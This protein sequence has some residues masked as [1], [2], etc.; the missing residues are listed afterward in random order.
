MSITEIAGYRV[1]RQLGAGGMGQ[2]FL[3]EHPRLPRRDALKLLDTGVSRNDDFRSRFQREA[4]LLAQLSHP[5][6][7]TLYDRGEYEDRLWITMEYVEG[8]DAAG[9]LKAGG[10]LELGLALQLIGGA[11]AALDYAWR[12]HRITHRD[13]KP[14][15]IL[16]GIDSAD[17]GASLELESIKLAD[18]GIAKAA[19]ETTSLTSTGITVGTMQYISPEAIEGEVLDNRADIYSLGCTAFHLLTGQPP[20]VN[21]S[22]TALMKAHLTDAPPLVGEYAPQLSGLNTVFAKVLAKDPNDRFQ[23]CA[24]F[25]AALGGASVAHTD[26]AFARTLTARN[27]P[28]R[29]LVEPNAPTELRASGST[30]PKLRRDRTTVALAVGVAVLAVAAASLGTYVVTKSDATDPVAATV[31]GAKPVSSTTTPPR[32]IV[33][34][35]AVANAITVGRHPLYVAITPGG[36]TVYVTQNGPNSEDSGST[37]TVIDTA[38]GTAVKTIVVD[39]GPSG[40]AIMP[41]GATAYTTNNETISVINTRTNA[42]ARNIP[43][44]AH[45][46][47]IAIRPDGKAAYIT[48]NDCSEGGGGRAV[49][50]FDTTLNVVSK[51]I[52]VGRCPYGVVVSPDGRMAY[53]TNLGDE[54]VSVIDT[55]TSTVTKTINV[56]A[57]PGNAAVLPNGAAVYVTNAGAG[58]VSVIDARTGV[59]TNTISVG[60]VPQQVA[61][62]PN[63]AVGYVTSSGDDGTPGVVSVI[64]TATNSVIRKIVAGKG[65]AGVAVDASGIVYVANYEN[66]TVSVLK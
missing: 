25:V 35:T 43:V 10:P 54:T 31:P 51:T 12:K 49:T 28:R 22:I 18:F 5:N 56:G 37:V 64:D 50:V 53:V 45:P 36:A 55:A 38:S 2:V 62:T 52:S 29:E 20:Y 42:L 15:N 46:Q 47:S 33:P 30:T 66:D 17:A 13:V 63:G 59:V 3:V 34:A 26:P 39:P 16:I 41:D 65:S 32:P 8:A 44:A 57:M 23:S 14:A 1:I 4:D 9:L 60:G 58:T 27:L 40:I 7:V 6:I 21:S 19:G 61:F 48:H 24:D 11:G